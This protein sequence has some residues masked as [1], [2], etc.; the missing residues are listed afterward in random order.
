[1]HK[2]CCYRSALGLDQGFCGECGRPLLRCSAFEECSGLLDDDGRCG[3]CVAP[4]LWLDA[5]AQVGARAGGALSLPLVFRNASQVARPLF[6]HSLHLRQGDADWQAVQVPWDRLDAQSSAATPV[7]LDLRERAGTQ[8]ID[9]LMVVATRWR[10]R[11]ELFAFNSGLEVKVESD[12]ALSVQQNITYAADAP[13]TGATIY[14]P[15]RMENSAKQ[16]TPTS[17]A[18]R[19]ME[20]VRAGRM[21]RE[22]GLRSGPRGVTV[23]RKVQLEWKGWHAGQ[24]PPDGPIVAEEGL[25]ILGRSRTKIAGGSGDVRLLARNP[26]GEVDENSSLAI[27]RR[28]LGLYIENDRLMLRVESERGAWINSQRLDR[29][30]AQAIGDG[31]VVSTQRSALPGACLKVRFLAHHDVVHTVQ[32]LCQA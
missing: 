15:L 6:L 22:F 10:W 25:L 8:H 28:H 30:C 1:M 16:Q 18:P 14:A 9:L 19:P 24:V 17:D 21:E 5:G 29:G 23:P 2:P 11:E 26:A 27:S 32:L 31:D 12:Q 20:L 13:Q 3:I 7:T 4:E